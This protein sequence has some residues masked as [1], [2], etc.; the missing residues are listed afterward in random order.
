MKKADNKFLKPPKIIIRGA[1]NFG[2]EMDRIQ[3]EDMLLA[4]PF[5]QEQFLK[6]EIVKKRDE[7]TNPK[8]SLTASA[9]AQKMKNGKNDLLI[10]CSQITEHSNKVFFCNVSDIINSGDIDE[11]AKGR[12]GSFWFKGHPN[13]LPVQ[14]VRGGDIDGDGKIDVAVK[15]SDGG[16]YVFRQN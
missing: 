2:G 5:E 4:T 16:I 10:S 11:L 8:L 3:F 14:E 12:D 1:A 9:Y 7:H 15:L 6:L 13:L